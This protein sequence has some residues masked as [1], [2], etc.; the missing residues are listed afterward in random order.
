MIWNKNKKSLIIKMAY[1][2]LYQ[3]NTVAI[4]DNRKFF[5][6]NAAIYELPPRNNLYVPDETLSEKIKYSYGKPSPLIGGKD[7]VYNYQYDDM[8]TGN[9]DVANKEVIRKDKIEEKQEDKEDKEDTK[10]NYTCS[11][12]PD[13][14]K[15]VCGAGK[16]LFP[17]MD[18]RFNLRECAKNMIL[19]EDHLFHS[20]KQCEDCIKKHCL[21]IEALL[22]E[23]VTLDLKGDHSVILIE[24]FNKFRDIFSELS[25]KMKKQNLQHE[26]CVKAA[27]HIRKIRKPLCQDYATF[28]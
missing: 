7:D 15:N 17:I 11:Y 2:T 6:P 27:Q 12:D 4:L 18:A 20:G 13:G 22:E 25:A 9:R 10:E 28:L 1:A 5:K 19:L 3:N 23:G 8:Y 16:K 24:T 26:D 14:V 21:T